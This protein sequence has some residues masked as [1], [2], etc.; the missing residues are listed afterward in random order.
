MSGASSILLI[1][2]HKK[3]SGWVARH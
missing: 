2:L 1:F 3:R